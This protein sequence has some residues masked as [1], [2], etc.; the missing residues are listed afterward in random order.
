M[1]PKNNI[2]MVIKDPL[3]D[4]EIRKYLPDAKIVKYSEMNKYN[5]IDEILPNERDYCIFLYEESKNNGHWCCILKHNDV[6]EYFD[7]YGGEPDE[8]LAWTSCGKRRE[9]N[10]LYPHLSTLLSQT[11]NEVVY[12]PIK[13]QAE[14]PL[15]NTC[16]RHSILRILKMLKNDMDLSSYYKFMKK[17]KK[18]D[19]TYDDVVAKN[20]NIME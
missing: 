4:D 15:V 9:L 2:K 11:P 19:G 1:P 3:G 20:I 6:F 12:N 14:S 13:Y 17:Q 8:P 5:S 7:S 10:E 18:K 16:G